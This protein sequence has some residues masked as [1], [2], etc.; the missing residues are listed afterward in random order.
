M[1]FDLNALPITPGITQATMDHTKSDV[2]LKHSALCHDDDCE[3]DSCKELKAMLHHARHCGA[4][5][6]ADQDVE[7]KV[8]ERVTPINGTCTQCIEYW[9]LVKAHSRTCNDEGCPIDNCKLLRPSTMRRRL[10]RKSSGV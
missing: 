6:A 3:L 8:E 7:S 1:F 4:H 9:D 10:M 2:D 5:A